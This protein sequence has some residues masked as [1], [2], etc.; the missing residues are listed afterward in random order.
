M[1]TQDTYD[2][3][4]E[5]MVFGGNCI[6]KINGKTVFIPFAVPGEKLRIKI[7][8]THKDYDESSIVD[9]LEPSEHRVQ[10]ICPLYEICGGCTL[11]HIDENFQRKLRIAMLRD[12]FSREGIDLPEIQ[13]LYGSAVGYRSRFQLHN[14]GLSA[15]HSHKVVPLTSCAIAVQTINEY[16]K[17]VPQTER[18]SGRIHLF[19]DERVVP[20]QGAFPQIRIAE[21]NKADFSKFRDKQSLLKKKT[22]QTPHYYEGSTTSDTD[23]VTVAVRGKNI[24]FNVKGFFQSNMEL[25]EKTVDLVCKNMGGTNLLDM[26]SGVGT[27]SIFLSDYFKKTTL[28]EH[29]REALI[30]A[31]QNLGKMQHESYGISGEKWVSNNAKGILARNGRYDAVIIDPPRSGME[32]QVRNWLCRNKAGQIRSVSCNPATHARDAAELIKSGYRLSKLYLL[33][34]YPQTADIESLAE[35]EYFE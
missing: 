30:F 9:I 32:K 11:M 35:F 27:F 2:I 34:F 12:C 31:E 21:Q 18:P 13:I 17:T 20:G 29:N 28:V 26:Y 23:T 6:G 3:I 16:L 4:A 33:D 19:G 5:K 14:G 8:A 10:P 22:K 25:L 24:S 1:Q 15:R 7:T